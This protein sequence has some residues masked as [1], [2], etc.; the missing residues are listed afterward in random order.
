MMAHLGQWK[1]CLFSFLQLFSLF[2]NL[3]G[4]SI[5]VGLHWKL[6]DNPTVGIPHVPQVLSQ[7]QVV[8]WSR[9]RLSESSRWPC[10]WARSHSQDPPMGAQNSPVSWT[11]S[12]SRQN[13][14]PCGPGM[15][16]LGREQSSREEWPGRSSATSTRGQ[17]GVRSMYLYM[18][19]CACRLVPWSHAWPKPPSHHWSVQSPP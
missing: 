11:Q 8:S 1:I 14:N 18:Y 7:G 6:W 15:L 16:Q 2:P 13:H 5:G 4:A 19:K 10:G 9:R 3:L 17:E 12:V